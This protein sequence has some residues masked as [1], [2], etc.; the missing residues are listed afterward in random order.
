MGGSNF[1]IGLFG[2]GLD[3]YWP[4]FTGL[5]QR[6]EG[7]QASIH[8]RLARDGMTVVDAG[9]VDTVEKARQAARLFAEARVEILFLYISTYALS[10]TVLPVVQQAITAYNS[11]PL[12]LASASPLTTGSFSVTHGES[13]AYADS[14]YITAMIFGN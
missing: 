11:I 3:T 8:E 9:L 12:G 14:T 6:L 7:Y 2:I 1:K 10:S 5:R 13:N 4:Q